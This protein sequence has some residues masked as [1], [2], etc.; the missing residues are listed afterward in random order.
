M[1][2]VV[3]REGGD[4]GTVVGGRCE[5]QATRNEEGSVLMRERERERD[6]RKAAV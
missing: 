4:C 2:K 5:R 6:R 1:E 3:S